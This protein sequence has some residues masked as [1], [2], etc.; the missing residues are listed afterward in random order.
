MSDT[1]TITYEDVC[2]RLAQLG[3]PAT[4]DDEDFIEYETE[5]IVNYALNYC[6]ITSI[7][8]QLNYRIIDRICSEFLS[9]KKESGNL[10]N[11]DYDAVVKEIKEGDTTVKYALSEGGATPE[12]RF[13]AMV[14]AMER[15]FDKWL[16]PHRRL[17][18]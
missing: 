3:Y 2:N 1:H 14:K 17:R 18:W 5:K 16:T 4:L 6:N 11:F 15:G 10:V 8:D 12:S 7:P 13:D 9:I